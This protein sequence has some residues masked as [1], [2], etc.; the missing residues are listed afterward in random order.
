MNRETAEYLNALM[1]DL[2]SRLSDSVGVVKERCSPEERAAYIRPVS[3]MLALSFDVLG[4]IHR[5]F[6]DLQ[7][8]SFRD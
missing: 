4:A 5:E 7:P 6:P 8:P 1:L 2:G 3:Q